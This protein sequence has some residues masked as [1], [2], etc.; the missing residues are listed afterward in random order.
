MTQSAIADQQTPDVGNL[1]PP[2]KTSR[3]RSLKRSEIRTGLLFALP[4]FLLFL[5]FRFGPAIVGVVLSFFD[6]A[7]T[8]A[9]EWKGLENFERLINDQNFWRALRVTLFYSALA[10]PL[11]ILMSL[12]MALAIRR[13]FRG[14]AFFRS[15]YFLPVI[16]SL[17][18]AGTIFVWIFS[19]DG[20]VASISGWLGFTSESWLSSPSLVIPALA[21]VG[22]WSRFGY[23]MLILLAALQEVPRELEEAA[24][25][26]GAGPF[27]RF[28]Y[29]V[30][31]QIKPSLFFLCIIEMTV[32]FQ[33]FDLI[34]VMTQGGPARGSYTLVYMLYDQGFKYT[35]YGYA[36]AIGVALF[37]MTLIIAL[38]QSRLLGE[39][40]DKV[41]RKKS[42]KARRSAS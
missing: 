5:A 6:Y 20:P 24:L 18:L 25:L 41:E 21:L 9:I 4:M 34:Y 42:R 39:K 2:A 30:L 37:I 32:S 36:A 7:I 3:R 31:P 15:V 14:V 17:V 22:V 38:I 1:Q 29:V 12:L 10:V 40:K 13:R 8:G 35:N 26:D 11:G 23:G 19:S 33:V 28:R 27:K 16:T